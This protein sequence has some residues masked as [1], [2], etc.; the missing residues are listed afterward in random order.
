MFTYPSA[1]RTAALCGG[2]MLAGYLALAVLPAAAEMAA[3]PQQSPAVH[4]LA[5]HGD[6]KYPADF[7]HFEYAN[8]DAPKGGTLH[9]A[10][11]GTF[12]NLN[13]YILKGVAAA[14]I[15]L[16]FQT[17]L[18][19]AED[20]AFTEYGMIAK[21]IEMPEDRGQVTFNLHPEARWHDGKP[22][23]DRKSTRL[24]SSH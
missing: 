13:P 1:A 6:P 9:L 12:D 11:A 15:T 18:A 3:V 21:S 24:N 16:T 8:P 4:A 23:T 20:E 7:T 5:M 22:L 17:L 14:G 19:N 10:A 2:M